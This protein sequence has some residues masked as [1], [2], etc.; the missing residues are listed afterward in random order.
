MAHFAKIE[1]NIVIEVIKINNEVLDEPNLHFPDTE[2]IGQDFIKNVLMIDGE[3]KQTSYNDNFRNKYAGKGDVYDPVLD[4]FISKKPFASWLLN[5]QTC[6]WESPIPY[7]NDGYIYYWDE[8][9]EEWIKI[10]RP[11]P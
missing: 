6:K 10:N 5:T 7:P 4:A 2:P 3:W 9:N 1:N 11:Q 8:K